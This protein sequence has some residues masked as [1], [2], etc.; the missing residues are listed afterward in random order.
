MPQRV[1]PVILLGLVIT[2]VLSFGIFATAQGG[3]TAS[4]AVATGEAQIG[5][6]WVMATDG[7]D[8]FSCAGLMRYILRTIGVDGNAPWTPEA[9]LSA[10]PAADLS[11]LQPGDIVIYPNWATMYVGNGMLLNSNEMLGYVTHTS[12]SD[13][14]TPVGA[15]RPPYGGS[16]PVSDPAATNPG[17]ADPILGGST[18]STDP[19]NQYAADPMPG[20]NSVLGDPMLG[21]STTSTDPL[22]QYAA[23]PMPGG[24]SALGDPMLGDSTT[25]T[26]PVLGDQI[27]NGATQY[28]TDPAPTD[29]AAGA[30]APADPAPVAPAQF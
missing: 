9:Y 10:Y 6:P 19:L 15:V 21:D 30:P 24:N 29:P 8:T 7:P 16:G 11:N 20:G 3:G 14:G 22:N 13:A 23:D 5:K 17:A 28:L 26:D 25:S 1:N 2:I 18:M 4:D 12:M 27:P